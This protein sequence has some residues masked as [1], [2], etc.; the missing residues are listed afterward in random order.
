M[1]AGYYVYQHLGTG[2]K[3]VNMNWF[4]RIVKH[5]QYAYQANSLD[6]IPD[7]LHPICRLK[8]GWTLIHLQKWLEICQMPIK[9]S[10]S[11]NLFI[12]RTSL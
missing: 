11:M 6:F 2:G 1:R 5:Y 8:G 10:D 4:A 7:S 9:N 3:L 12:L